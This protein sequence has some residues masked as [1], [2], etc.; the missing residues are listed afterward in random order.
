[1]YHYCSTSSFLHQHFYKKSATVYEPQHRYF[2]PNI[3]NMSPVKVIFAKHLR[4]DRC[5]RHE[6]SNMCWYFAACQTSIAD[7]NTAL[8]TVTVTHYRFRT[9]FFHAN[10]CTFIT[11][12]IVDHICAGPQRHRLKSMQSFFVTFYTLIPLLP[13]DVTRL[14]QHG[15]CRLSVSLYLFSHCGRPINVSHSISSRAYS[16]LV[17]PRA[18]I[19]TEA[20]VSNLRVHGSCIMPFVSW[21]LSWHNTG[22][23]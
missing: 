2:N 7:I 5:S 13:C 20:V 19:S 12:F 8:L 18:S 11:L 23:L 17:T 3:R 1:M 6:C 4:S 21:S 15:K 10:I 22:L 9:F 14:P 16:Y